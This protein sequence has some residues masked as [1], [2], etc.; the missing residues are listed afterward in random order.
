[1]RYVIAALLV[2]ALAGVYGTSVSTSADAA[3]V[4][5]FSSTSTDTINAGAAFGYLDVGASG[6]NVGLKVFGYR[7]E[8]GDDSLIVQS[9]DVIN[10]DL[11][12]AGTQATSFAVYPAGGATARGYY[13]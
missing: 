3:L 1:M 5:T 10:I 6:G 9:G 8:S 4:E 2:A 7:F 11:Y 13:W 12:T